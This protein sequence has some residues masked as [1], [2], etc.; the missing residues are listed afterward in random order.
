MSNPDTDTTHARL[1]QWLADTLAAPGLSLSPLLAPGGAGFS[2]EMFFTTARYPGPSGPVERELVVRRQIFGHD[3]LKDADLRHQWRVMDAFARHTDI[4][5]PPLV[6]IEMDHA[7]LGAPFLVMERVPGRIVS[8]N[9]NYNRAGWLADL[10]LAERH[11]VWKVGIE[12]MADIHRVDWRQGFEFLHDPGKGQPGLDQYLANLGDWLDWAR[13]GRPWPVLE[14]AMAHLR[15][16]RPANP[17]VNV[18]WGDPIPANTLFDDQ[19]NVV[20][21]IDWEMAALGPGE[22]D[23]AWWLFFDN[24]FSAGFGVPRLEGLPSREES[25]AIYEARVGR[26]VGDMHYYDV[27]STLRMAIVSARQVDRQIALGNLAADNSAHIN[28]P[29]AAHLATLIGAPVP[30]VGE[31]FHQ[32]M[33][34]LMKAKH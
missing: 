32:L 8:Q 19:G 10:P 5:V 31:D 27:L 18:L 9:P 17:A 11:R 20:A 7:V 14:A 21:T 30:A 13:A 6:G 24:L 25:I 1:R 3:L 22:I 15:D 23:L 29:T 2:A 26:K 12:N 34:V 4:R 28:N 16:N 33:A